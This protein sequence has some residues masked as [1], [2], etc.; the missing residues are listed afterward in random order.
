MKTGDE[1]NHVDRD[2]TDR[3]QINRDH[4]D[5]N[6]DPYAGRW[7]ATLNNQVVGQGGSPKQALLAAQATRF[8]EKPTIT[9][10]PT[11]NP[12]EFNELFERVRSALPASLKV[13]L[14]GGA[15]RDMLLSRQIHDLDFALTGDVLRLSRRLADQLGGA[16]FP[17]DEERDTA[18]IVLTAADGSR[19]ILDMA[20]IRGQD[21][22]ADLKARDFTINA[23]AIALDDPQALL[24]PCGG[25]A[26]LQARMLRACSATSLRNDPLRILR[27][28]RQA[29][30]FNLQIVPETRRSMKAA[31]SLLPR[32]SAER[33]RDELF[34]ILETSKPAVSIRA[35]DLLGVLPHIL[36][37]LPE[38]KG[39]EQS[40]P[41]IADVWD[42]TLDVL[43]NLELLLSVLDTKADTDKSANW[44]MGL[45]SMRLG[46]FRRQLFQ[47]VYESNL[48]QDRSLLSL[49]MLAAL[50]HDVAK[51]LT[52]RTEADGRI[53][54]LEHDQLGA[55]IAAQR[56]KELRLSNP[57]L[58]RLRLIVQHHMRPL[59][60]ANTGQSPSRRAIYR[61]F[62]DTTAAGVDICLLSL[63]DTLATYGPG[64]PQDLWANHIEVVRTLLEA[65]WEKPQAS[66]AP[67]P[68]LNGHDL[69]NE[70]GL[71]P[72]PQIGKLIE[73][74]REAQAVGEINDLASARAL[75]SK[76]LSQ[77][78][79]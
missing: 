38:L 33:V 76:Y 10:V 14:V 50:Y 61:Y 71:K 73:I 9:Y 8:K 16:Y 5:R 32:V 45:V 56:G 31:A 3:N 47:H 68:L 30:A 11:S 17:L 36:P 48:N 75:V 58:E 77:A 7:I 46:R 18:R 43:R 57:E 20:A 22:D 6:P 12:F 74:V 64:L 25:A 41:H 53:R 70:F 24:D 69:I 29:A 79:G 1:G 66:V 59:F 51:P 42:H 4:V 28:I 60:L 49:L 52:Q 27:G 21:I 78:E 55:K 23:M 67:I 26:D 13:Y 2:Q 15:V 37:E 65:W 19:Q 72:G 39:V 63:A 44:T 54:F 62:R 40:P 34:H 35:L